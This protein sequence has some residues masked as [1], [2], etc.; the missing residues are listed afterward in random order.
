MIET[1]L[2]EIRNPISS[3]CYCYPILWKR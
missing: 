2:A 1:Q 3:N